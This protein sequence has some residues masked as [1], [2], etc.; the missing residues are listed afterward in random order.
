MKKKKNR[1]LKGVLTGLCVGMLV[2]P[3]MNVE[4]G[5][6]SMYVLESMQSGNTGIR[7]TYNKNGLIHQMQ[8]FGNSDESVTYKYKGKTGLISDEV[9]RSGSEEANYHHEYGKGGRRTVTTSNLYGSTV[10]QYQYGKKNRLETEIWSVNSIPI[11]MTGN[12]TYN[13]KGLISSYSEK[14]ADGYADNAQLLSYDKKGNLSGV[15]YGDAKIVYKN[16]YKDGRL[17]KQ[18]DGNGNVTTFKYKKISVDS[19]YDEKIED[20]Q[21]RAVNPLV[22]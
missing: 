3:S 18:V 1:L 2:A 6:E 20:Q 11:W 9:T 22:P 12:Y 14:Y 17:V 19:K 15:Q 5:R 4:A 10:I 7:Y 16:S 21:W 8:Y 13:N